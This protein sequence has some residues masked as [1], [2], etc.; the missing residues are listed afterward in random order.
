MA[1]VQ[2]MPGG[3]DLH[4]A[5]DKLVS[6]SSDP[7]NIMEHREIFQRRA[8]EDVTINSNDS[9]MMMNPHNPLLLKEESEAEKATFRKLKY[10]YI[11]QGAKVN[12]VMNITGDEPMGL[13]PGEN[14]GL[15][16]TN[17]EKKA[18]LKAVKD[19]VHGVRDEAISLAKDNALRHERVSSQV[20]EAQALQKKIR[21][22]ELELARIKA[23][24]PSGKRVTIAQAQDILEQQTEEMQKL[25]TDTEEANKKRDEVREQ[26]SSASKDLQ[27]LMK[28]KEREEARAL[29]VQSGREAGDTKV[30]EQC[31]WLMSSITFYKSLMGIRNV[32]AVSE[33]QLHL[34]YAVPS[35]TEGDS[36][37]LLLNFDSLSK[38]LAGAEIMGSDADI[39]E[40]VNVAVATNDIPGLIADVLVLVRQTV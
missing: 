21:D 3:S 40:P 14:E 12:F 16:I 13:Q 19:E 25:I 23:N 11:E 17:K 4:H 38:R 2:S 32:K 1:T 28:D 37:V 18:A 6:G 10:T 27:R 26:V 30:D 22:M 7:F 20:S 34:E 15:Q 36:V 8:L 9:A 33:Y 24:Y 39:S 31:R 35:T 5:V 29:E